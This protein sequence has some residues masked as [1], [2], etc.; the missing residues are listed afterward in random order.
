M[1]YHAPKRPHSATFCPHFAPNFPNF[2]PYWGAQGPPG[3]F[4]RCTYDD[5]MTQCYQTSWVEPKL[6][7]LK[8][9]DTFCQSKESVKTEK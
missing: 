3:P 1:N 4:L 6:E 5:S 7:I 9:C 2:A 8:D